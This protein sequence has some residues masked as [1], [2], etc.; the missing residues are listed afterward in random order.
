MTLSR[1]YN[2]GGT[3]CISN[4]ANC[5]NLRYLHVTGVTQR[6]DVAPRNNMFVMPDDIRSRFDDIK[7]IDI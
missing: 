1:S 6:H 3:A 7:H 5:Y 2:N 4:L